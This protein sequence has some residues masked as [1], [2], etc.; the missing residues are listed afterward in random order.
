MAKSYIRRL[1]EVF[2]DHNLTH[3]EIKQLIKENE[4]EKKK[5]EKKRFYKGIP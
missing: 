5:N 3:D 4:D 1:L 2:D